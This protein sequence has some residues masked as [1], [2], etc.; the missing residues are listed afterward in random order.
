MP[1][2]S[3]KMLRSSLFAVISGMLVIPSGCATTSEAK[4]GVSRREP[5]SDPWRATRP[6]PGPAP[7]FKLPTFQK[8]E[9]KN[10]LTLLVVE[11]H[12]LPMVEA[13][14]VVRAGSARESAREAGLAALA[15][16][17][18][19]EGAGSMNNLA[20]AEAFGALGAQL[21]TEAASEY[22]MARVQLLKKHADGGLE[23]LSTVVRKPTFAQADFERVR[24][25]L[26]GQLK[27]RAGDPAAIA[28]TVYTQMA[29]GVDH[30]YGH[31]AEGTAAS[32]E[33]LSLSKVKK[34]WS[35]NAGPKNAAL[36][37]TG[38]ITLDEAKALADKHFGKWSGG[39]KLGKAPADPKLRDKVKL[40][41]VDIPGAPQTALRVGRALMARGDADEGALIVFNEILGGSFSSRLNLKLREEKQWTYGAGSFAERRQGKGPFAVATDVQTANSVDAVA[42][43]FAQFE[44]MKAGPTDDEVARAKDGWV[45]SLPSVLGLPQVQVGSAATLFVYGLAPDYYAKL[46]E[47][48][49]AVNAEAVKKMA[50]RALIKEDFVVVLV[51]DRA[52]LE[53]ALKEKAL[54]DL[55]FFQ[56]DGSEAK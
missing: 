4:P 52:T 30:P 1:T 48:V 21:R 44:G 10:G 17:L 8:A 56:R 34:F 27:A 35:D 22:G 20:L 12:S 38:D 6:A 49:Q 32:L 24:A 26:A 47:S 15:Y 14:V 3:M 11:E 39:P 23:L 36:V 29:F 46:V 40:G 7:Q 18:L 54:G 53:P 41:I 50:E 51:G 2:F 13:A 42:E 55:V 28:D 16:A 5:P 9:L 19:D 33:K 37:L 43:I 45:K 25:Q 31:D